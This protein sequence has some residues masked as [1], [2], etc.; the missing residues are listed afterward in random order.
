MTAPLHTLLKPRLCDYFRLFPAAFLISV[1]ALLAS[2]TFAK[3]MTA[4]YLLP[5]AWATKRLRSAPVSAIVCAILCARP[6]LLSPSTRRVGIRKS[7]DVLLL[8]RAVYIIER[9]ALFR[10]CTL[11]TFGARRRTR[12]RSVRGSTASSIP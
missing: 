11:E 9:D 10:P 1:A 5:M 6:G 4:E 8:R 7:A 2:A 3:P 12:L